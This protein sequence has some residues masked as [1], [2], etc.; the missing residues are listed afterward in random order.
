M[1]TNDD[2]HY[3]FILVTHNGGEAIIL[4]TY[5]FAYK[6]LL[7]VFFWIQIYIFR[8][9]LCYKQLH[10]RKNYDCKNQ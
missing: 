5:K 4:I 9:T 1:I 2:K 8:L 7:N 10:A 3:I 6:C